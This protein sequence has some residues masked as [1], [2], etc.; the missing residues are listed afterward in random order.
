MNK[1]E[2][3]TPLIFPSHLKMRKLSKSEKR[4]LNKKIA[5][6]KRHKNYIGRLGTSFGFEKRD[7][8]FK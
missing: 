1:K 6:R 3:N 2:L 8:L 5:M 7:V 4:I